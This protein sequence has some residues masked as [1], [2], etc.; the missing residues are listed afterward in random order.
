MSPPFCRSEVWHGVAGFSAQ[1]IKRLNKVL[2]GLSSDLEALKEKSTSRLILTVGR[3]QFFATGRLRFCFLVDSQ[4]GLLAAP[5]AA[6]IPCNMVPSTL[7][8]Q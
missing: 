5:K 2:A 4:P 1:G 3:I 7:N 8:Q 6:S